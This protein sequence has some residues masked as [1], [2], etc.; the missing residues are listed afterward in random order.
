MIIGKDRKVEYIGDGVYVYK[1]YGGV[2]LLAND[3]LQPTDKIYLEPSVYKALCDF[4]N[5]P[6]K[7]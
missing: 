1:E 7:T 3:H 2:W 6:E 4:M 5:R